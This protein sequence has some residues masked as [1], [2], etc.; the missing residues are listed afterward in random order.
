MAWGA[1][2]RAIEIA[3]EAYAGQ[4]DKAGSDYINHLLRVMEKGKDESEKLQ[5]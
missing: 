3:K 4:V 1:L 2:D 5:I